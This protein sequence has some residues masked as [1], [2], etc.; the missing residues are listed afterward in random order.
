M[1]YCVHRF[2]DGTYPNRD[3]DVWK[4]PCM[5]TE[6]TTSGRDNLMLLLG[7]FALFFV[8]LFDIIIG[9]AWRWTAL[10]V[11]VVASSG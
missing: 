2:M 4:H 9:L 11:V 1:L 8:C 10:G 7:L 6:Q 5:L 3:R